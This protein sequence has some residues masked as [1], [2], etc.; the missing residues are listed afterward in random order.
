LNPVSIQEAVEES[1][2]LVGVS[3]IETASMVT[4]LNPAL[5]FSLDEEEFSCERPF[6]EETSFPYYEFLSLPLEI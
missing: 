3:T 4:D 6:S 2:L 1:G 5:E